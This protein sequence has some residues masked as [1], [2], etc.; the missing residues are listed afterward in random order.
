MV[1]AVRW[2]N[3]DSGHRAKATQH[4]ARNR[5]LDLPEGGGQEKVGEREGGRK[6]GE[7]I[8]VAACVQVVST[9][10]AFH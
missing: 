3:G 6:V 1:P 7:G 2:G 9:S 8:S 5:E 4:A 10:S